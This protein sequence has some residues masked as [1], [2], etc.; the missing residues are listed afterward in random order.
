MGAS[1]RAGAGS[2]GVLTFLFLLKVINSIIKRFSKSARH[3]AL[4][5]ALN[6]ATDII[7][8]CN[9]NSFEDIMANSISHI[10][11]AA[12]LDRVIV[13]SRLRTDKIKIGQSYQWDKVSGGTIPINEMLRVLPPIPA[14]T[15]WFNSLSKNE[16]II[17]HLSKMSKEEA[18]FAN[19]IGFKSVMFVPIF[20][21]GEFWGA[22]AFQSHIEEQ[23]FECLDL[24]C[25]SARLCA[26]AV[27]RNEIMRDIRQAVE[28]TE[29]HKKMADTLNKSAVIFISQNE[30]TFEAK[31]TA[32]LKLICDLVDVN[33]LSIWRNYAGPEGLCSSQVY[34][35]VR[36]LGGTAK[37][38]PELENLSYAKVTPRW[39]SL[40]ASG[41]II[42]GPAKQVPE[43][44][45]LQSFGC[46]SVLVIPL[47]IKNRF[48][49]F[50]LFADS[51]K[52]RYFE[53]TQVEIMRS[54][55]FLCTNIFIKTE[56]ERKITEQNRLLALQ[57][58]QQK[59]ASEIS[60]NFV[61]HEDSHKLI[62]EAIGKLGRS[63]G[64][65]RMFVFRLEQECVDIKAV[66]KWY[67]HEGIPRLKFNKEYNISD[68]LSAFPK[69]S[70][71]SATAPTLSCSNVAASSGK[72]FHLLDTVDITS[73]LY[74]PL[75]VEG[76]LWGIIS[77]EHCFVQHEWPENEK[78]F[79]AMISSIISSAIMRNIHDV[80]LKETL[81]RVT[82]LSKAK[83]EFL[84]KISHEIR[85]PMNAILGITEIQLQNEILPSETK[86]GLSI[87]YNSGNS[88]LR[89]I[90]DLLDLSKIE[91]KKLEIIPA[92]YEIASLINDTALLGMMRTESKPIEFKL[93]IGE[94]IPSELFGDELRIKQILNNILSN[95]F[96]YTSKGEISMS[97]STEKNESEDFDVTLIFSVSDTGQGMTEEQIRKIFDEYSRFNL[98]G[99]HLIEGTGLG[100]TIT[101]GLLSLMNGSISVESEPDKGSV[102]TVRLPQKTA[103]SGILSEEVR[104]NLQR[105]RITSAS[106]LKR[107]RIIRESMPYGKVLVVDDVE[108]N[109][110]VAERLLAPY[111]LSF[112]TA[113]SGFEAIEKVKS[114]KVYD[115]IF[116]DHMMPKMD[117]IETVKNLR[118]S[119]YP[120][121]IIALTA[122]AVAG[123]ADIFL[124]NGFDAFISKPI[125]IY[126]LNNE[127]NRFIRDKRLPEIIAEKHAA[128]VDNALYSIFVRDAKK[129]LPILE[130]ALENVADLSADD[131][132]MFTIK[133]HAMKSALANIGEIW[134]SQA[135]LVLEKAGTEG[136]KKAIAKKTRKFIDELK[137][138][139]QK[140]EAEK[141]KEN[142][143]AE[144]DENTVYLSEQLKII[145]DSCENY[146]AKTADAAIKD[147]KKMS[148]TE[149]TGSLIDSISEHLLHSD[150][151]EA[152]ALAKKI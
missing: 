34:R 107:I 109:L 15:Q 55:A 80:K 29:L 4:V 3:A 103:G 17:R 23:D 64:V 19:M 46:V 123:Q 135:A 137:S 50:A 16:L 132:H 78:S 88:L 111:N 113:A 10:A 93:A 73:V 12:N 66:C 61:S 6:K 59:L 83:D 35:W 85:T 87:I 100:M 28:D 140:N 39:E 102:F 32:G 114:G 30:E 5:D 67:A 36:T 58:E 148:W 31:M 116:M 151:E 105:F 13:Y 108:S 60:K 98:A 7:I 92:R 144:T 68:M 42:N 37:P 97:V 106:Q 1:A 53:D 77:A 124:N 26:S 38:M 27:I 56:M 21:H 118:D 14:I 110:Y 141:E 134:L 44:A 119:G 69:N 79:F 9:G 62:N 54:T 143:T 40:L 65:S 147:L 127:L 89:I 71:E 2:S 25:S 49:G 57:L 129:A 142:K 74:A 81:D 128:K 90:N 112:E 101:R 104:E 136:N 133:A 146:D 11:N 33:I 122:N 70:S 95:A 24:L 149:K 152:G 131:L 45:I 91:A 82:N 125:D 94:N 8:S 120:Y 22:V 51:K 75:Y 130:S 84:S 76:N 63:L 115:I 18:D 121:P 86:E 43:V 139:I 126:Q 47:F 20:T 117:G 150:F 48:W 145:A 41:E 96:K 72:I 138:L 99:N 52:E